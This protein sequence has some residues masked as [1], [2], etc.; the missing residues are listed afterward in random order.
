MKT[1]CDQE[2]GRVDK[3]TFAWH[4]MNTPTPPHPP[5]TLSWEGLI[6]YLPWLHITIGSSETLCTVDLLGI[7][8]YTKFGKKLTKGLQV[9]GHVKVL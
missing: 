4:S 9:T 7:N 8:I 3:L 6:K 1:E 5:T 2:F